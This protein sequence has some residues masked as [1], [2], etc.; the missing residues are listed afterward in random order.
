ML[1]EVTQPYQNFTN[2]V[3]TGTT[4]LTSPVTSILH[5]DT[6]Q[7]QLQWTGS[8]VGTFQIQACS[9]YKPALAQ[10]PGF[11][12]PN[13][14]TWSTLPVQDPTTGTTYTSVPTS[15]G[16]PI[17]V[18]LTQLGHT[19][20]QVVYTNTSGTGTLNGFITAKSLG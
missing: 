20:I 15:A 12:A 6:V 18:N 8:P 13:S 16:S 19:S 14:G 1:K 2:A 10:T 5:K 17:S 7:V 3:M 11:G 9:D 4:T